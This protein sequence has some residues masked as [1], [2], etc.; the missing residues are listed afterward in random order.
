MEMICEACGVYF[1]RAA[2][3]KKKHTYCSTACWERCRSAVLSHAQQARSKRSVV[4][5]VFCGMEMS[6]PPSL[7]R[8]VVYCS[9]ACRSKEASAKHAK[10]C[11]GCGTVFSNTRQPNSLYCTWECF[12]A[13]RHLEKTCFVCGKVFDSYLCEEE[14]RI[15]R[16]HVPCCSRSCRNVYTSLLLGGDGTWVE[17]GQYNPKRQ[18]DHRWRMIRLEYMRLCNFTCEGCGAPAVDV[19]H[20]MQTANGGELYDFDNLMAVCKDCHN[21]MHE[22]LRS[23][24]FDYEIAEY[25]CGQFE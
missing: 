22:Q 4:S 10:P 13:S 17:G 23:G 15:A 8:G 3:L 19:H 18:R 9:R 21:N 16:G 1:R 2:S 5:C 12:K 24:A 7:I 20:L 25:L 6:R 14:K 11:K